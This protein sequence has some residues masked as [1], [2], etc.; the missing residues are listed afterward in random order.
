MRGIKG[1]LMQLSAIKGNIKECTWPHF[2]KNMQ[3]YKQ[4]GCY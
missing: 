3:Y 4:F 2:N 1:N